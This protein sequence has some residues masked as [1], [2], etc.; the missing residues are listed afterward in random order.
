MSSYGRIGAL[1]EVDAEI[2][3]RKTALRAAKQEA[4]RRNG[5][6]YVDKTVLDLVLPDDRQA[7]Q[8]ITFGEAQARAR[9]G[10]K[11]TPQQRAILDAAAELYRPGEVAY[12]A[13]IAEKLGKERGSVSPQISILRQMG[14]WPYERCGIGNG[15]G[16]NPKK[17]T[18]EKPA[19]APAAERAPAPTP[20]LAT[21]APMPYPGHVANTDPKADAELLVV[22]RIMAQLAR[23]ETWAARRRVL[24]YLDDRTTEEEPAT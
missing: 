24:A 4:A 2:E 14:L 21:T 3:A 18:A 7:E 23:L 11:A 15:R 17:A 9:G 8:R 19:P 20:P 5:S 10:A 1:N 6:E 13:A 12:P 16:P 22:Q